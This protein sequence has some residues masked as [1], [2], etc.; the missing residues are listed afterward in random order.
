M[1]MFGQAPVPASPSQQQGSGLD[2]TMTGI[3]GIS[4][5]N[6]SEF[7]S[8]Q[9]LLA[10]KLR[11]RL[12][13]DGSIEYSMTWKRKDTRHGRVYYQ[14]V[15]RARQDSTRLTSGPGC[16]GWPT[17]SVHN[18]KQK[19]QEALN[20]RRQECKERTGN[21]NG[22]GM[23]LGN[24]AQMAGWP[25][26]K[27]PTGGPESQSRK[28]E[29]GRM[30]GGDIQ[31]VAQ[32]AGWQTMTVL[33]AEG[34]NYTYPSGNHDKPF[35][36]LCGQAQTAGWATPRVN[37]SKNNGGRSNQ[38]RHGPDLDVQVLGAIPSGSPAPTGSGAGL[39]LNPRFVCWLMGFPLTWMDCA[40]KS[41]PRL[42]KKARDESDACEG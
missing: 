27:T 36:T 21:G 16:S 10:N 20:R 42:R 18:F 37:T 24:A 15:A 4:G 39:V 41:S 28:R 34:R 33:D 8:R 22:F 35:L 7:A 26:P 9:S 40:P 1:S 2:G 31:A 11:Q 17:A 19:D 23:T 29:L 32:T 14:L 12:D 30:G 38:G 6:L 5:S 25:T 3:S 13:W